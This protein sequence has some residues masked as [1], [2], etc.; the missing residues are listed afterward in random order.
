MKKALI[1]IVALA[2]ITLSITS[3]KK[4][5]AVN[6]GTWT[7]KDSTNASINYTV[8]SG[9]ASM[10]QTSPVASTFGYAY[11]ISSLATVCKTNTSYGDI[12]FNFYNYPT[13][14]G[15]YPISPNVY[16]DSGSTAVAINMILAT[17]SNML[18]RT[19]SLLP[20]VQLGLQLP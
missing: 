4:T 9:I 13:V 5:T 8:T 12:V 3:C 20:L 19:L 10:Y 15:T 2:L 1:G 7:F 6:G 17:G 16:I 11:Q 18:K 14:S